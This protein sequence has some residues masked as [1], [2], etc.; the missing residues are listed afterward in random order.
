MT[1]QQT[2]DPARDVVYRLIRAI[3]ERLLPGLLSRLFIALDGLE[4]VQE[5]PSSPG[6]FG[7]LRD[8]SLRHLIRRM[9]QGDLGIKMIVTSRYPLPELKPFEGTGYWIIDTNQV[10]DGT[11]RCCLRKWGVSGTD[12]DLDEILKA[13]GNHLL[14]LDHLGRLVRD[15][16]DGDY[17]RASSLPDVAGISSDVQAVRLMRILAF[18]DEHLP[19][20]QLAVLRVLC[21][22]RRPI[23]ASLLADFFAAPPS[24]YPEL[25]VV[26]LRV[27][28]SRLQDRGLITFYGIIGESVCTV[29]PAI[30]DYF[31]ETLGDNRREVHFQLSNRIFSL[32]KRAEKPRRITNPKALDVIEEAIHHAAASSDLIG[33]EPTIS[34]SIPDERGE[35][36]G[37]RY[38]AAGLY[39][40]MGGYQHIAWRLADYR[41]GLRITSLLMEAL[42]KDFMGSRTTPWH[43]HNL[44]LLDSGQPVLAEQ[45]TRQLLQHYHE[46][47]A[48]NLEGEAWLV[49]NVDPMFVN[50]GKRL[51]TL[52]ESALME[53]LCDALLAQG[54]LVEAREV[55]DDVLSTERDWSPF[56]NPMEAHT[57]SN[58]YGRRALALSLMG[59]VPDALQDFEAA[60]NFA[61]EHAKFQLAGFSFSWFRSSDWYHKPFH[62]SLL[63]RLGRLNSAWRELQQLDYEYMKTYRPLSTAQYDLAASEI[64]YL[65][66]DQSRSLWH[67]ESALG[68]AMQ[69]GHQQIY[70]RALI[71]QARLS[72]RSALFK[73][74]GALLEEAEKV[75]RASQFNIQLA[76]ALVVAGHLAVETNDLHRSKT[77]ASEALSISERLKYRWGIGDAAYLLA[78]CAYQQEEYPRAMER[79]TQALE[80]RNAIEDPRAHNTQELIKRI[81]FHIQ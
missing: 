31:S 71:Q 66:S 79:A 52:Y 50:Y 78:R 23:T 63:G 38:A 56:G 54:K 20:E 35:T 37:R 9:A 55:I 51:Y 3:E 12:A 8:S 28:L 75:S 39:E 40:Y 76:D 65:S 41:R 24:G 59:E 58:P 47:S 18:Y 77:A 26:E 29:H 13:F 53:T 42:G 81:E 2:V 5:D 36:F 45:E 25:S 44:F 30:R 4:I 57:G 49:H 67:A 27:A 48:L 19:A 68:W 61:K 10:D 43:D 73:K 21:V 11:A 72:L 22:L 60:D 34:H 33:S 46:L 16:F 74:V 1:H 64:A 17:T 7:L 69:S 14:T 6:G 32:A 62:A 15:Y 80:V 70:A